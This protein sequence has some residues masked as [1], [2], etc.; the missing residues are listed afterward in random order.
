MAAHKKISNGADSTSARV[1]GGLPDY[2]DPPAVETLL[3]FY[4]KPLPSWA[5]LHFGLFWQEIRAEYPSFE[6]HPPILSEIALKFELDPRQAQ[7]QLAS[8]A[9]VRCW[10]KHKSN[11]RLIQ[12]Q[13]GVFIQNWRKSA[14]NVP[15]LHYD[16]LRPTF[17]EMWRLFRGFLS[18]NRIGDPEITNCEVTY[19]NHIDR[20]RGWDKLSELPTI[21]PSWSG[22]TSG[23]FLPPPTSVSLNVFY[24]IRDG[25]GRLE[26]ILQPGVRK[27]D[28][29]ETLQL[30]LTARCRPN[31]F[32]TEE[33]LRS[34]DLGRDWVVRGFDDFTSDKMHA[35]WGKRERTKRRKL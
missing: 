22:A 1:G 27:E 29:K 5:V 12:I 10:F 3:G 25:A 33:L 6:V 30:V 14:G 23:G 16:E 2:A 21:L 9:P 18:K 19:I 8:E 26:V 7:F 17:E 15:Y 4:F 32:E 34:L 28:G 13:N 31:S 20:G 24:P 35:V 11:T